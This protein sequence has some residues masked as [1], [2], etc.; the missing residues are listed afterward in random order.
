LGD[1]SGTIS[2]LPGNTAPTDL[3]LN[4]ATV[5][6][7][8]VP[9]SVVGSFSTVDAEG[10]SFNYSLVAGDGADDNGSF[11]IEN[12]Q[13]KINIKPDFETKRSYNIRVKTT[14]PGGLSYE[15]PLTI[16]I[17]NVNEAPDAIND[18]GFTGRIGVEKAIPITALL[19]ND[20][21]PDAGDTKTITNVTSAN[22]SV[23]IDSGNILFTPN[24]SG[25]ATFSYILSDQAGLKDEAT[26]TVVVG[27]TINGSKG[28]DY[29]PGTEGDDLINGLSG[30]DNTIGGLGDDL[31]NGGKGADLQT[32]NAG[33]DT[34]VLAQKAG[35][36][37]ITD[38]ENG[39]DFLGLSGGL[40]FGQLSISAS[41]SNTLVNVGRETLATLTGVN[42]TL[43]DAA[44]FVLV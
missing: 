12:D 10:G 31:L 42:S 28:K 43:I 29:L 16:E 44:D 41:G 5:P 30:D 9:L 6:E 14:D 17:T 32:G 19:S 36:D 4:P 24:I 20:T 15:K 37:I 8:V 23:R 21:D 34:F 18:S 11:A 2:D 25:T 3:S 7:N 13:L 22:G 26:V 27:K 1:L 35:G 40:S 38:F 39:V 33:K